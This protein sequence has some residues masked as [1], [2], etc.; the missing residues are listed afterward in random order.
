[1]SLLHRTIGHL[2]FV[3]VLSLYLLAVA[4]A[5]IF[6]E[7]SREQLFLLRRKGLLVDL[8]PHLLSALP[9][10]QD[11]SQAP[12]DIH[13]MSVA[14]LKGMLRDRRVACIGCVERQH[15]V[16]RAIEVRHE[17]TTDQRVAQELA[18]MDSAPPLWSV[19]EGIARQLETEE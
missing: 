11:N 16:E 14:E 7:H 18:V 15:L 10:P 6:R 19:I 13:A 1:M 17:P 5:S 2:L 4:K 12:E 3:F 9:L 8:E